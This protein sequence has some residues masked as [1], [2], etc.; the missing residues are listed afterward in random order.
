MAVVVHP[1]DLDAFM[2]AA[3]KE[4]LEASVVA[5]VTEEPVMKL[6]WNGNTIVDLPR[7][8]IDTNGASQYAKQRLSQSSQRI[9]WMSLQTD[10]LTATLPLPDR[11]LCL[12]S[13]V[14][15]AK[16]LY[17]VTTQLSALP[18]LCLMAANTRILRKRA[19]PQSFLVDRG[20]TKNCSAM[21][22]GFDPYFTGVLC[23]SISLCCGA[24][25]NFR[26]GC[27]SVFRK[28]LPG[29][30]SREWERSMSWGKPLSALLGAYR[31]QL[32]FGTAAIG[33]KDSMSGTF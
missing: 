31:A 7:S 5:T 17:S 24:F 22:Y 20:T 12:L 21:T 14:A 25:S 29:N 1:K 8:F 9:I 11:Y 23:R 4:N 16:D 10:L 15:H 30:I 32:D 26:N 19:W 2:A 18:Q 3:D 13:R 27:R 33:G 28:G 6:V